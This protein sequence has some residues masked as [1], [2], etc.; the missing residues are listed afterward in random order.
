MPDT[1]F[2]RRI[3]GHG[4][5]TLKGQYRSGK[6]D[7]AFTTGDHLLAK[8]PRQDELRVQVHLD[9]LVPIFIGMFHRRCA[10]NRAGVVDQNIDLTDVFLNLI[11]KGVHGFPVAEIAGI[12][13]KTLTA[14][15]D[16][17]ADLGIFFQCGADPNDIGAG[18]SQGLCE[19][20]SDATSA[21]GDQCR[22]A[23]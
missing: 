16:I 21:T 18:L 23:I 11:G 7:L 9:D 20:T 8:L 22:L 2:G 15:G 3:T 14:L 5:P 1:A 19:P 12:A 10:H 6:H 13:L 4:D 17:L